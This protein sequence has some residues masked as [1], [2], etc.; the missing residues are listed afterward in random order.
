MCTA[1]RGSN[2]SAQKPA[3]E[4][5]QRSE[6]PHSRNSTQRS[7]KRPVENSLVPRPAKALRA[8]SAAGQ[9]HDVAHIAGRNMLKAP[10]TYCNTSTATKIVVPPMHPGMTQLQAQRVQ[11]KQLGETKLAASYQ[12][13]PQLGGH[14]GQ[15]GSSNW[16]LEAPEDAASGRGYTAMFLTQLGRLAGEATAH[17]HTTTL[18]AAS[19]LT[20]HEQGVF[21]QIPFFADMLRWRPQKAGGPDG[22]LS[23]S[24]Q[25]TTN[26]AQQHPVMP[27]QQEK[28]KANRVEQQKAGTS[29]FDKATHKPTTLRQ[30]DAGP[31]NTIVTL[32]SAGHQ[33]APEPHAHH[34]RI[35]SMESGHCKLQTVASGIDDGG[36]HTAA[37]DKVSVAESAAQRSIAAH[38][39]P[40]STQAIEDIQTCN[41]GPIPMSRPAAETE[42][43]DQPR[44]ALNGR[45]S[46]L[47]AAKEVY[48]PLGTRSEVIDDGAA[49]FQH[50]GLHSCDP[51]Q[52][53]I[54]KDQRERADADPNTEPL[55]SGSS[56][57]SGISRE[58]NKASASGSPF[59]VRQKCLSVPGTKG[60]A[61]SQVGSHAKAQRKD[62]DLTVEQLGMTPDTG[63]S[64][65]SSPETRAGASKALIL[66]PKNLFASFSVDSTYQAHAI[67][68]GPP[69]GQGVVAMS[70][71][72][73]AIAARLMSA[74]R[75]DHLAA[76][77]R[78]LLF[79]KDTETSADGTSGDPQGY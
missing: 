51:L 31:R 60:T 3:S 71:P 68:S 73:T 61:A 6:L 36:E 57:M 38:A 46:A 59:S 67:S 47:V 5:A 42:S 50:G 76:A 12:S 45:P 8:P 77:A 37:H 62:A 75:A 13:N 17:T 49:D 18:P 4:P 53:R 58:H 7:Q 2:K 70:T 30:T 21:A 56:I 79:G 22:G 27:S 15:S 55:Q 64:Q 16:H 41:S 44:M 63:Q 39:E 10:E 69:V 66:A 9:A 33:L 52:Q 23:P 29:Q 78:V 1:L 40:A 48:E 11:A 25:A 20:L 32:P 54:G 34:G 24:R 65:A 26:S 43:D 28:P 19:I 74:E 72:A 35:G 14:A